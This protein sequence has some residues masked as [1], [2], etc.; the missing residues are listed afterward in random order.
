M[1]YEIAT[2][3]IIVSINLVLHNISYRK[4]FTDH[5]VVSFII[6]I[7]LTFYITYDDVGCEVIR[8]KMKQKVARHENKLST[9]NISFVRAYLIE[10][11]WK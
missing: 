11:S 7:F 5:L 8:T 6:S 2:S 4:I 10:L 1:V 3:Y 9:C